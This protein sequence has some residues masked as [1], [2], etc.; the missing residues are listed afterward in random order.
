MTMMVYD[1]SIYLY[2]VKDKTGTKNYYT[3]NVKIIHDKLNDK[4][5]QNEI[6]II[7]I[8]KLCEIFRDILSMSYV[9]QKTN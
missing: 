9:H 1:F 2:V 8:N 4:V 7:L 3:L 5:L 6:H